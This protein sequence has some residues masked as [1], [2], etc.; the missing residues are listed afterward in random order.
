MPP[1][2]TARVC[3][4]RAGT[5]LLV[6]L[7]AVLLGASGQSPAAA[8]GASAAVARDPSSVG[9]RSRALLVEHYRKHGAAFGRITQAEYLRRAQGLRDRPPSDDVLEARRADGV[10]TRFE[11][12]TGAFIAF[13]RD[14][15]IRTFFRPSDGEAY[16]RRQARREPARPAD[17]PPPRLR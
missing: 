8:A 3:A 6:G 15:T 12:S 14:L 11:R 10:V 9:F 17:R 4:A 5:A 1:R 13:N 16:F 7:L 2:L